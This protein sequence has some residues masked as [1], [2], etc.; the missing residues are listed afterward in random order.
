MNGAS[1]VVFRLALGVEAQTARSQIECVLGLGR[2]RFR[3]SLEDQ[4]MAVIVTR[5]AN[6]PFAV[7]VLKGSLDVGDLV[8]SGWPDEGVVRIGTHFGR[9]EPEQIEQ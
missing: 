8:F 4:V 6:D 9:V 1:G 5:I 7:A 2:F 3:R